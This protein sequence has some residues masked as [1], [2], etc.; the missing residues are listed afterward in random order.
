MFSKQ[1]S[2]FL[3]RLVKNPGVR[4]RAFA[5]LLWFLLVSMHRLFVDKS[6]LVEDM[7]HQGTLASIDMTCMCSSAPAYSKLQFKFYD[8]DYELG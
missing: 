8:L 3:F 1:H 7:T 5:D 2:P 4:K 6:K